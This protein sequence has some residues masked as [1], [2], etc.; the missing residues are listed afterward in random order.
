MPIEQA[1][2]SEYGAPIGGQHHELIEGVTRATDGT[3]RIDSRT[4][5]EQELRMRKKDEQIRVLNVTLFL[6]EIVLFSGSRCSKCLFC[7]KG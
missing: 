5:N 3:L 7:G 2:C 4:I 6:W 1:R